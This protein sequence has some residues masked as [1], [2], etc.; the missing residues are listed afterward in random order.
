MPTTK[1][2]S[3]NAKLLAPY[4]RHRRSSRCSARRFDR[5]E[6]SGRHAARKRSDL[7]AHLHSGNGNRPG[8]S[9]RESRS[10]ASI[11]SR[12]RFS[13][14]SS[15]RSISRRN[16]LP[17]NVQTREERV[18]QVFGVKI[19]I[20]DP[21]HRVLAGMAADVK[22]KAGVNRDCANRLNKME[23]TGDECRDLRRTSG[24]HDSENSRR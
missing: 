9:G 3:A 19:R 4:R 24:A 1:R 12:R 18:H 5:A 11:L 21:T 23:L 10:D 13:T 17:R 8:A 20:D 2:V 15:N 16:F 22:L 6:Y 14:A 7:R